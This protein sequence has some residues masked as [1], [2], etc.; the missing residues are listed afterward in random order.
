MRRRDVGLES[1]SARSRLD[2]G[3]EVELDLDRDRQLVGLV[4]LVVLPA[5][6]PSI[7]DRRAGTT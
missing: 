1:P 4:P 2:F 3:D 7:R 6:L 5:L